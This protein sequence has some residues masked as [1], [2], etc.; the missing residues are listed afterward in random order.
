MVIFLSLRIFQPM[1]AFSVKE[2]LENTC[3]FIAFIYFT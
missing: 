1:N 2:S 3:F